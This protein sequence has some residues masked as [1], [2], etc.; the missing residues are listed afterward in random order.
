[1]NKTDEVQAYSEQIIRNGMTGSL[2]PYLEAA[3]SLC[4]TEQARAE[5]RA[6]HDKFVEDSVF[7][8][9]D[10]TMQYVVAMRERLASILEAEFMPK[11]H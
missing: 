9:R 4:E 5:V 7:I 8:L 1:M 11:R 6:R 10:V 3:L 2:A